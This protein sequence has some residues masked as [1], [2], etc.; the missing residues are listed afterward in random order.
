MESPG[1]Q[2]ARRVPDPAKSAAGPATI[3]PLSRGK[4]RA[5]AGYRASVQAFLRRGSTSRKWLFRIVVFLLALP[6]TA[7]AI[8]QTRWG[9]DRMRDLAIQAIRD[10]VGLRATLGDVAVDP[11]PLTI[12]ARDIELDDPV[13]GRFADASVLRI[14]PSIWALIQGRVDL[15]RVEIERPTVHLV[16]REGEIRNLPRVEGSG[17]DELPFGELSVT[18]ARIVV[19]A[20]PFATA[21]LRGVSLEIEADGSSSG[22]ADVS[23]RA[24]SGSVQHAR[25]RERIQ[26]LAADLHIAPDGLEIRTLAL[27]TPYL[28]VR[29]EDADVPLPFGDVWGG[30]IAATVNVAHL[31]DLPVG[32][33]IPDIA[34]R[35][36]VDGEI[37]SDAQGIRGRGRVEALGA[38]IEKWGLGDVTIEE[39]DVTPERIR[40][41]DGVARIVREGGQV[42][43]AGTLGL[44][45]GYRVD[46]RADVRELSFAR[47]M[48][49]LGVTPDAIVE[50]FLSGEVH[51]AGTLDPLR[52]DGPIR[53]QT[54]GFA[55]TREA[56]HARPQRHVIQVARA[57]VNGSW[58]IR[59]DAVRFEGIDAELAHS[60]LTGSVM[61]GFDNDL[62]VAVTTDRVDLRDATPLVGFPIGGIGSATVDVT[63]TFSDPVVRGHIAF[64]DFSFDTFPLGNI[65]SDAQLE[66]DGYSVRFPEV[67]AQKNDSRYHVRDLFLDFRDPGLQITGTVATDRFTLADLYHVF[68][69]QED[70]RFTSYQGI[71]RGEARMRYT[72][73]YPGDSATG[74]LD[75][76]MD[77]AIPEA[78]LNGFA[79]TDGRFLGRWRW[80]RYE[81]GYRG[82][83]LD[84]EHLSLRKGPGTVTASGRM[85]LD[86]VLRLSAA[87]DQIEVRDTEG[88]HDRLPD[89]SGSYG[90]VADIGG[91][92]EVPRAH[93]DVTASGLAWGDVH[94]GDGRAYVR[95]TD[96]EDPWVAEA[97]AWDERR[98]P[99]GVP[100]A[101]ARLG[102]ARGRWRADPPLRT[103][104]G[105]RPRLERPMAFLVCGEA[106]GGQVRVD[107][108]I[109]RTEVYPLRGMVALR[110]LTLDPYLPQGEGG[111][112]LR[113]SVSGGIWFRGGAMLEDESLV[114]RVRLDR[115][116]VA[117]R[118]LSLRNAGT[119]D[120]AFDRGSFV[121]HQASFTGP[122]S[123]L[124]VAGTGSV[125]RGIAVTMDGEIDLGLLATMSDSLTEAQG[126]VALHV[127]LSGPIQDP[128]IFGEAQ[129]SG[130][131][132]R[133]ASL[134]EPLEDLHGRITFSERRVV[135][136]GFESRFAGGTVA[137][138][139]SATLRD[140]R[141]SRY[142]LD[143]AAR[144][145]TLAPEEGLDV[146]FDADGTL[147]WQDGAR[148]PRLSGTVALTRLVYTRPFDIS[149]QIGVLRGQRTRVR[150]EQYDPTADRLALDL[151][152]V[153]RAPM[154]IDNGIIEAEGRIE[155]GDAPFRILGTDQRF[156][157]RGSLAITRG[158]VRL[159]D[160]QFQLRRGTITFDDETQ[161]NPQ[162]SVRAYTEI[163]RRG[164]ELAGQDWR[165]ELHAHGTRDAFALDMTSEPQLSQED[166]ALLL[167]FGMTRS[168]ADQLQTGNLVGGSA[169][170][171][172]G[173]V[174]GV[175]SSVRR[176]VGVI[177]EFRVGTTYSERSGTTVA[178][179][180]VGKRIAR[181]VRLTASTALAESR[182]VQAGVEWE[183]DDHTTVRAGYD[184][185]NTNTASIGNVG[186]DVRWRFE[187]D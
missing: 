21:E 57:R 63:G 85:G 134:D 112:R 187:F 32:W 167:I 40:V 164:G 69:Y 171:A 133:F 10:E 1:E 102:L 41:R 17:S 62:R 140:R 39:V 19:D 104:E 45:P 24:A 110:D 52:L 107:L 6:I 64:R 60:R 51:L 66:N 37:H 28:R 119:V 184:N 147:A 50:W 180:S 56:W 54:H 30:R 8:T 89:L 97:L 118:D 142:E 99:D 88:L 25:G 59:P 165:L 181:R 106:L 176:A 153:Q 71:V 29:I 177:D 131:R 117:Q 93:L 162:F 130:G 34:G 84:I 90:V 26:R 125:R 143:V 42:G 67:V 121:I 80:L 68:H 87:A 91:T 2:Q 33:E 141:I 9:R 158:V 16:V 48:D 157:A 3:F 74:T 72:L 182:E 101:R 160:N 78:T 124:S 129:V 166:I 76:D 47:L 128:G 168:E 53:T 186:V 178:Q 98:P 61:L 170:E 43:F 185:E 152:V 163:R 44:G 95:L 148:L 58:S 156:G 55:V 20:E 179:V 7:I 159:N 155:D 115:L 103:I 175:E 144:G 154:R 183:A 146:G 116:E 96:R 169:L 114:G 122:S 31:D 139:G 105:L 73:G 151:R 138:D 150:V 92:L 4:T 11:W 35:V 126:R 123:R 132:F 18:R 127:N 174:S 23:M 70:E 5:Y 22:S 13:Y 14:Q 136:D 82:G 12:I 100:C 109:G 135:L 86:G 120:V 75:V 83:E 65:E 111:E 46:A 15:D 81:Q 149:A 27:R 161:I 77:L 145:L 38:R 79:F 172:L 49:Q 36:S 137:L 173:T 108:A 113:G 94:L